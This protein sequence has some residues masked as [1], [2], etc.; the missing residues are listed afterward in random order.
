[1]DDVPDAFTTKVNTEY[2]TR[3]EDFKSNSNLQDFE[4]AA[5]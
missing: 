3:K 1:M 2:L 5:Q 4:S